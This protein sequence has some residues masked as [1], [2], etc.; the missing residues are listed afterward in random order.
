MNNSSGDGASRRSFLAS[1]AA[2]LPAGLSM[3]V[4]GQAVIRVG[5]IGCGGRGEAA[6]IKAMGAGKDVRITALGG[7]LRDRCLEKRTSF[8]LKFPDQV[9]VPDGRIFTGFQAFRHV[10][11]SSGVVIIAHAAKFHPLHLKTAIESGRHVFLET[12]HAI[13]PAS[14]RMLEEARQLARQKRLCLVSGL[15]SRY[16]P[17]YI[18]AM[19]KVHAALIGD[20]AAIQETWL[21]PPYVVHQRRPIRRNSNSRPPTR[22]TSTGSPATMSR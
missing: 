16:H 22:I 12:P 7:F 13:D 19:E 2:W 14:I 15:Q 5:V 21:R 3:H 18:E 1:S 20:I 11:E 17:R 6:A 4:A 9:D 10:I 8:Q